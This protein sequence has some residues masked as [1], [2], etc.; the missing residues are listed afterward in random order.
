MVHDITIAIDAMGGDRAPE[1]VIDGLELARRRHDGVGFLIFG[2]AA[3]IAK[4]HYWQSCP[5]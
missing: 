1:I 3:R 4:N 2:D 5:L